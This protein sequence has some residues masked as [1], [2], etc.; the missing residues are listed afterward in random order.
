MKLACIKWLEPPQCRGGKN[1]SLSDMRKRTEILQELVY[2]IFDSILIPLIRSNFYVT[3]SNVHR[4]RLFYFRHDV[5]RK[6]TEPSLTELKT[7][8]FEEMPNDKAVRVLNQRNLGFSQLRLLPKTT[9]ARPITNL[10]RRAVVT[11]KGWNNG[12]LGLSINSL[13]TPVFNMLGYEKE[14]QPEKLGSAMFSVQDMYPKLRDFRQK[15]LSCQPAGTG[16]RSPK[17]LFFVKLD[18]KSCFDTIPQHKLLSLAEQLVSEDE[19]RVTKHAEIRPPEGCSEADAGSRKP[20]RKFI[21]KARDVTD[22]TSLLERVSEGAGA[23]RKHTVFV[24]TAGQKKHN[25]QTLLDLLAEHVRMNLVKIG[26]KYYRQK[27]GIPQGSVLSSLLCNFF[28]G[29]LENEVLSFLRQ[30]DPSDPHES[31]L[32]RLIDDFLLI[33]T[34]RNRAT[35]F[36]ELM[37]AGQPDYGITVNAQKSLVNFPITINGS[38]IPRSTGNLFPYCGSLIDTRTLEI[39]REDRSLLLQ[40]KPSTKGPTT[41][42][43]LSISTSQTPGHSFNRKSLSS[44]RFMSSNPMFLDTS[45]NSSKVVVRSLYDNFLAAAMRMERYLKELKRQ[46]GCTLGVGLVIKT[47]GDVMDLGVRIVRGKRGGR[48]GGFECSVTD[49]QIRWLAA[50]AFGKVFGRRQTGYREVVGWLEG[51]EKGASRPRG[52]AGV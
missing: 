34:D 20:T 13:M 18:I 41:S 9:G 48:Q 11:S 37:I 1:I 26:K 33:T 21:T 23:T 25:A 38:S 2:Y 28:Y 30:S 42:D 27:N 50:R 32:L 14:K 44:F 24:D 6:L 52:F 7:S 46:G 51:V 19:Y 35:R 8:V 45:H 15:L 3:E 17:P 12:M 49:S 47:I 16:R 31:L 10:R 43:S 39:N 29:D 40:P 22:F 5:W 4:N 36:L